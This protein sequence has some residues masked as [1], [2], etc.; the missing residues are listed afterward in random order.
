MEKSIRERYLKSTQYKMFVVLSAYRRIACMSGGDFA[1]NVRR[2][3]ASS[4]EP[5]EYTFDKNF[6]TLAEAG[7]VPVSMDE[8]KMFA[9]YIAGAYRYNVEKFTEAV[10]FAVKDVNFDN[11][12]SLDSIHVVNVIAE[13]TSHMR[14]ISE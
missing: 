5:Q 4:D 3:R 11:R 12:G 7:F 9:K 10:E 1:E 6:L 2:L 8:V 13:V 14:N